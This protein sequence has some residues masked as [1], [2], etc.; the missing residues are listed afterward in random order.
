VNDPTYGGSSVQVVRRLRALLEELHE[1]VRPR[2]RAAVADGLAR[3]D[4]TLAEHW[5]DSVDLDLASAADGQGIGGPS[6]RRADP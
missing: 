2:F 5:R 3:L 6:A 1:T 4:T